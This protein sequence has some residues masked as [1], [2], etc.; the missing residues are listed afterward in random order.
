MSFLSS[1]HLVLASALSYTLGS[2]GGT[3]G[4]C[5]P[6]AQRR[7]GTWRREACRAAIAA[8]AA[9]EAALAVAVAAAADAA[10]S[11]SACAVVAAMHAR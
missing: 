1:L 10:H 3:G 11:C 9:A 8:A 5:V 6:C 4:A 2:I 7:V